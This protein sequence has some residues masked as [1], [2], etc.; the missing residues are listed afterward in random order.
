M[1]NDIDILNDVTKTL[2]DSHKGYETCVDVSDDSYALQ[3]NFRDRAERRAALIQE[4]QSHV[5]TLGGEPSTS[6]SVAGAAHRAWTSF[7]TLFA[8]DEK[9]AIE[10][11]DDGEEYLAEK[12]EAC[13][14]DAA[15]QPGTRELLQKAYTDA[16]EGERFADALEKAL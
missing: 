12:I 15:I 10:A 5:R 6:G 7:T 14:N 3:S 16:R 8:D 2:I 1:T 11:I 13:L 9:A 4:F